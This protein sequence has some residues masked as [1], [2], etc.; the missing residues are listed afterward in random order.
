[1]KRPV[2][3]KTADKNVHLR[4]LEAQDAQVFFDAVD[5]NRD[6]L[7]QFQG[8]V[9]R[10]Y[11]DIDSV[12]TEILQPKNPKRI[13]FGI[14]SSDTFVGS[15]SVTPKEDGAHLGYWVDSRH[16]G[17]GYATLAVEAIC[18]FYLPIYSTI[19]G[20]VVFGNVNS[21]GVLKRCGFE[22]AGKAD[23]RNIFKIEMTARS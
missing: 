13:R 6:H 4:V 5:A 2:I 8:I 7:S 1:M 9:S 12:L 14:W 10:Q 19:K 16:T 3:L 23:D 17:K 20:K 15:I 22:K 11:P 18:E 21:E